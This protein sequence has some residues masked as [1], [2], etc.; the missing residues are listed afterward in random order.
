VSDLQQRYGTP[1]KA[2]RGTLIVVSTLIGALFLGWLGW[3]IWFRSN[4]AIEADIAS[5]DVVSAHQVRIRI[6][7][8]FRDESVVRGDGRGPHDRGRPDAGR[9]ADAGRWWRLDPAQDLR[10]RHHGPAAQV[11]GA[12]TDPVTRRRQRG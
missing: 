1:S 5:F 11:H 3:A 8:R 7:T 6:Q 4:P 12:L 2:R 10:S 9:E